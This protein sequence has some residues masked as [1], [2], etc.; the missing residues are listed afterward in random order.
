MAG[1]LPRPA[2]VVLLRDGSFSLITLT[3]QECVPSGVF[4]VPGLRDRYVAEERT[5]TSRVLVM[6]LPYP[7]LLL[8]PVS[9]LT[10]GDRDPVDGLASRLLDLGLH[11]V[12]TPA[13]E[14]PAAPG[15]S[16]E[17][18]GGDGGG[19]LRPSR[20]RGRRRAAGGR[21]DHDR[22]TGAGGRRPR[23]AADQG[24]GETCP[25]MGHFI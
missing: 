25:Q 21:H 17:L 11:L 6:W 19:A 7:A 20:G 12:G 5:T 14:P 15:W 2:A 22:L 8:E 16:V 18:D 13:V 9:R 10:F 4:D 3:H 23:A 1:T 24:V